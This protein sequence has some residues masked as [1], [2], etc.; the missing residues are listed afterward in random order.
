[1]HPAGSWPCAGADFTRELTVSDEERIQLTLRLGGADDPKS[2]WTRYVTVGDEREVVVDLGGSERTLR[3]ESADIGPRTGDGAIALLRVEGGEVVTDPTILALCSAGR[4][5]STVHVPA[6]RWLYRYED[7]DQVAVW[8]VVDVAS[9]VTPGEE[10]LLQP[11]LRIASPAELRPG[12][13]FD[14]IEGVGLANLPEKLR[15]LYAKTGA[16]GVAIPRNAR[17]VV[18]DAAK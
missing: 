3:L 1:M 13:R 12:I 15:T 6:G 14:E 5:L 16:D 9:A 8:G 17:Y 2:G 7:E 11:R 18:L 10:L 4:A